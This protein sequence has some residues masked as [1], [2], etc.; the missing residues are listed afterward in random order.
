MDNEDD[1]KM[2]IPEQQLNETMSSFQL[3]RQRINKYAGMR[4]VSVDNTN[5][6]LLKRGY[7]ASPKADGD[8]V[9][10][11]VSGNKLGFWN[12]VKRHS[13]TLTTSFDYDF[14]F[15]CEYIAKLKLFLIFDTW[16]FQDEPMLARDYGTR[17]E[18]ANC[19]L[20]TMCPKN[21]VFLAADDSSQTFVIDI[22]GKV[23]PVPSDFPYGTAWVPNEHVALQLKPAYHPRVADQLW[24]N[25]HLLPYECDGI[26]FTRTWCR[27]Q[28]FSQSLEAVLKWKLH[29]TIDFYVQAICAQTA[30]QKSKA[31]IKAPLRQ[32]RIACDANGRSVHLPQTYAFPSDTQ[33]HNALLFAMYNGDCVA[34]SGC[35]LSS[36]E[37]ATVAKSTSR[38]VIPSVAD[39]GEG[40]VCEF[41]WDSDLCLWKFQRTRPDKIMPNVL[42]TVL[43]CIASIR[44]QISIQ[45]ISKNVR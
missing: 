42:E 40:I 8:T 6:G 13:I 19:F 35:C 5:V 33:A 26:I 34:V 27:Y 10:L 22:P 28:P 7:F 38:L 23:Q 30:L 9:C 20:N 25:R 39:V 21:E 29:V 12:N 15:E 32:E 16:L 45:E 37:F 4:P 43:A 2:E 14:M 31:L 11:M 24:E 44:D 18:L 1:T 41:C 36:T 17:L 3:F